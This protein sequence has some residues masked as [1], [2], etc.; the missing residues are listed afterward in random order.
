M[1]RVGA[2]ANGLAAAAAVLELI[3]PH[4][5]H[6]LAANWTDSNDHLKISLD[7]HHLYRS[8]RQRAEL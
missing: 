8:A 5:N 1:A 2:G 3:D 6:R 4:S 7:K